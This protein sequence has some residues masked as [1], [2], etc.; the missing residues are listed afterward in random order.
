MPALH[1]SNRFLFF[2]SCALHSDFID[3]TEQMSAAYTERCAYVFRSGI[4]ITLLGGI[5]NDDEIAYVPLCNGNV[6]FLQASISNHSVN[7][8]IRNYYDTL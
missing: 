3:K 4:I 7:G 2:C 8:K 1:Y 6:L 5:I